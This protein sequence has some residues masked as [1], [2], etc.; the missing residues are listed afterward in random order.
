MAEPPFLRD[1]G[2]IEPTPKAGARQISHS[3]KRA[4]AAGLSRAFSG[5]I[6]NPEHPRRRRPERCSQ[7]TCARTYWYRVRA[8][9]G[10][11]EGDPSA[12]ASGAT[13]HKDLALV[14][15]GPRGIVEGDAFEIVWDE[16]R[17]GEIVEL[18]QYDEP[19]G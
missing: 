13:K 6:R 8:I 5:S 19:A 18:K 9:V 17:G 11:Q 14:V 3:W 4:C 1:G 16:S 15:K 7:S 10:G 12:E 2:N